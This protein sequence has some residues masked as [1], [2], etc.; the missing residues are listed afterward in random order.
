MR[1]RQLVAGLSQ[2][3]LGVL[4]YASPC[5][6]FGVQNGSGAGVSP[7]ASVFRCQYHP[8]NAHNF[9]LHVAVARRPNW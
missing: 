1:L 4:S 9:H 3:R 6:I 2:Q 8:T 5:E 7:S